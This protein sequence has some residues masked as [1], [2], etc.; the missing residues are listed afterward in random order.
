MTHN[1][2]IELQPLLGTGLMLGEVMIS[3]CVPVI[4][5]L[6]SSRA[7]AYPERIVLDLYVGS[8][9]PHRLVISAHELTYQALKKL[10]PLIYCQKSNYRA[11]FDQHLVDE[12]QKCLESGHQDTGIEYPIKVGRLFTESGLHRLKGGTYCAVAGETV[13]AQESLESFILPSVARFGISGAVE[14]PLRT[15]FRTLADQS[16]A[17]YLTVA[18]VLLSLVRSAVMDAGVDL[19]A[20]L[21]ITGPQG[22][23]KTTLA[24]RAAG[25][26]VDNGDSRKQAAL[27]YG[28]G[29]TWVA[30]RDAMAAHRDFPMIVDDLCLSASKKT[31]HDRQHLAA[32]TVREAANAAK[33]IKKSKKGE[34]IEIECKAGVIL[35][36]EFT[37]ENASDLTRCI[38]ARVKKPL[39]LPAEFSSELM[40]SVAREYLRYFVEHA[41]SA[42]QRLRDN[43][44]RTDLEALE[45]CEETRVRTNLLVLRWAFVQLFHMA[46][47]QGADLSVQQVLL[48]RFD[49]ALRGAVDAVNDELRTIRSDVP[50]GNLAYILLKAVEE[51]TFKLIKNKDKLEK[52]EK[53]DGI[54]FHGDLCLRKAPLETYVR[55][56]DGFRRWKLSDITAELK[57]YNALSIQEGGTC[58]VKLSKDPAIPRV[59]RIRMDALRENAKKY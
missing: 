14:N 58:Q 26:V 32:Q 46:A 24:Q 3:N 8:L 56:Q 44:Q 20:V 54:W 12:V 21:Y 18:F 33:I 45:D 16:S 55:Q 25:F 28:A 17:V 7:D 34:Q 51:K 27:F 6:F 31:I 10:S 35:T 9:Q 23:G 57:R 19:Q 53:R 36:A 13:I 22:T 37:L 15:L 38:I 29:G 4:T 59:Y 50:E 11:L 47:E 41:D 30:I 2:E 43:L 52:L 42:L 40:G 48:N 1:N 49:D 5:G 39:D